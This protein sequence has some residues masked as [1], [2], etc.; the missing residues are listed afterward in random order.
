MENKELLE[1]IS[2]TV[3][4]SLDEKLNKFEE[5]KLAPL[6]DRLEKIEA[7]PLPKKGEAAN[8][9]SS[10]KYKGYKLS[11]MLA[12]QGIREKLVSNPDRYPTLSKEENIEKWGKFMVDTV[13]YLKFNNQEARQGML[14]FQR[15]NIEP[16]Y[17]SKAALQEGTA[18]EGGYLVPDEYLF[19]VIMLTRD[20]TFALQECR[21][22]NMSR[23]VL[24]IPS[25]SSLVAVNW[26]DEEAAATETEPTFGE[27]VLTA[28]R[29]DGYG[30][31]SN[32]LL[33]DSAVDISGMLTEQFGYAI[34]RELDNEVLNGTGARVSGV[35]TAN[36]GYSV[37]MS[38]SNFSSISHV[39]LSNAISKVDQGFTANGKFVFNKNI[40]HFIRTQLDSNNRPI[41]AMPGN[42]VPGTV[43][44]YPYIVSTKAPSTTGSSTAFIAFGDFKQFYIGRR[45]GVTSLD[46]DP[47][48]EFTKYRTRFR[49]V[50]R[51]G[52]A[53]AQPKAFCR[54]ITG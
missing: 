12:H 19:D 48:G 52:L 7:L 3:K 42:G 9:N 50:T 34:S 51:W 10:A 2:E 15:A 8:I 35:L 33:A 27:T 25:E 39:D 22:V 54:I 17:M 41:F 44:E 36:A 13:Q 32:E 1:K 20:V 6:N 49:M 24:R 47:Y 30:I 11:G 46:I 37:V 16:E 23:D 21:M 26:T 38:L 43:Y 40:L 31:V 5:E 28:K 29:L 45:L 18:D 53:V 4:G 14:D